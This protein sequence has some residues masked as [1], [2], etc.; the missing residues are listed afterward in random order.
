MPLSHRPAGEHDIPVVC[1]F[2]HSAE[3]RHDRF[4]ASLGMACPR[5]PR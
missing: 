3:E 5:E 4:S 2:P 1:G